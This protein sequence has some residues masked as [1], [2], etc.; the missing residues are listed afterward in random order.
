MIQ[1][2]EKIAYEGILTFDVGQQR[3]LRLKEA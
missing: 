1:S 3:T 2:N